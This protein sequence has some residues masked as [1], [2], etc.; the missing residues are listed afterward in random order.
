MI[1]ILSK[2]YF[3]DTT[4]DVIDW[5]EYFGASYIRV[6]GLDFYQNAS[7]S[8]DIVAGLKFKNIDQCSVFWFRR[9]LD[10]KQFSTLV[11]S[12]KESISNQIELNTFLTREFNLLSSF[13]WKALSD[14]Y[15]LTRPNELSLKKLEVLMAAQSIGLEVPETLI[16]TQKTELVDFF[17][18]HGRI[19]TKTIGDVPHFDSVEEKCFLRTTE[20]SE[21]ILSGIQQSFVPSL[22]Q[23]LIEKEIELRV[24]F[25]N[26][27]FYGMAIFSQLDQKTEVD[28]RNYNRERPNRTVPFNLPQVLVGQL[29]KLVTNLKLSTGSMDLVKERLT[30]KYF[31]LE[32][33]PVGQFGMTSYPCNYYLEKLVAMNL[34][35]H[36]SQKE[37]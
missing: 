29:R 30:G 33:N 8:T 11:E 17:R 34:M 26:E 25:I 23:R 4:D 27:M 37:P 28:F 2:R 13:L 6:N 22:F 31:L 24:F 3:E 35:N 32:I 19:I 9:W 10:E 36:D 1:C 16:T 15:W 14:R 18:R 7:F 12:F 5:L 20:I 21:S